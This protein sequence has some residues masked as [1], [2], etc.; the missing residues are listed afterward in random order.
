M[1]PESNL[2]PRPEMGTG[3]GPFGWTP[4]HLA[5][6]CFVSR[7]PMRKL[8]LGGGVGFGVLL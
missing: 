7:P 2:F 6:Q 3:S 5:A 4:L 1:V 8:T